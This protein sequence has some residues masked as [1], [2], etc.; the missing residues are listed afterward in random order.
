MISVICKV[1]VM[2]FNVSLFTVIW[3]I[4]SVT[5]ITDFLK[6]GINGHLIHN[7]PYQHHITD[8]TK[9]MGPSFC[10]TAQRRYNSPLKMVT[11]NFSDIVSAFICGFKYYIMKGSKWIYYTMLT[12]FCHESVSAIPDNTAN[13][14]SHT[15]QRAV[16]STGED[17]RTGVAPPPTLVRGKD[18]RW[19][20]WQQPSLIGWREGGL[21]EGVKASGVVDSDEL[22]LRPVWK[23][24]STL[25]VVFQ[26]CCRV[27]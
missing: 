25:H 18:I 23:D 17:D 16:L 19:L 7:A 11:M 4:S 14:L 27:G 22:G 12:V 24:N 15:N 3:H 1:L 20:C 6:D 5:D 13:M 26:I 2:S 8:L 9:H 21:V 10:K